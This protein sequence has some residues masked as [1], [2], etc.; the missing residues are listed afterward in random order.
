MEASQLPLWLEEVYLLPMRAQEEPDSLWAAAEDPDLSLVY[1]YV[2]LEA[3]V[4]DLSA[5]LKYPCDMGLL[6]ALMLPLPLPTLAV[7]TLALAPVLVL[8]DFYF[9]FQKLK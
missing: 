8:Q 4:G 5:D 9:R 3:V 1:R 2:S 7:S 6:G